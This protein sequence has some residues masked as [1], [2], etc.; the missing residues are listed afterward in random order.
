MITYLRR[1]LQTSFCSTWIY[2]LLLSLIATTVFEVQ[3]SRADTRKFA[4]I[5]GNNQGHNP[6][7]SLRYAE[8]DAQKFY[9][10]LVELGGFEKQNISLQLGSTAEEVWKSVR[11]LE[12]RAVAATRDT[13]DR[14]L[15][16]FYFS[17][18]ASGDVLELG[19][20]AFRFEDLLSF[21]RTS[22]A[23]VRLALIDSCRSG[24][25]VAI[26]GGS[27]GP[28]YDITV[29]D[30]MTSKGYAII[31][32]SSDNELSQESAEIRGAYFTHYLV[33][34]LRGAGDE[35]GD[36]KVTLTEAYSYAYRKTLARTT[37]TVVGSQHP[38]YEFQLEGRGDVVLT[39][40]KEAD[41]KL[42]IVAPE[43]GRLLL[44]DT[45]A[46]SIVAEAVLSKGQRAEIAVRPG[47]YLAYLVTKENA[48]R[49]AD[50]EL[51]PGQQLSLGED[52][53]QT[54][55][56]SQTVSKGGLFL[57]E[58]PEWSH[59]LGVGGMW[60]LW[61]LE[62][63]LSSYGVALQY[64]LETPAGFE[65]GL[66]MT[67]ATRHDVGVSKQYNDFGLGLYLGY[68][69]NW[70]WLSIR[71]GA[72]MA[73]EYMMQVPDS[74]LRYTSAFGYLGLAGIEVPV[75]PLIAGLESGVG[76]RVFQLATD[77]WVHRLDAQVALTLGWRWKQE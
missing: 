19:S 52:N 56:L 77:G 67:W 28:S 3:D 50:T 12:K 2:C 71:A 15:F 54:T 31:T 25:L 21:L 8:K 6:A 20:S 65:P 45:M 62:G 9:Q 40:T 57:K 13:D 38:M 23:D 66:R 76:G 35:S 33:S 5:L 70:K 72:T 75:G 4:V 26:K 1:D 10:V 37:T 63:A 61:G 30:E 34:S 68:V 29:A 42:Q 16:V 43:A 55:T 60:R 47:R 48:V 51:V 11:Q 41:A 22:T 24:K 53:F 64:R 17:G 46:D 44:L 32:S 7:A 59:R 14:S 74:G 73:Y 27:R 18:H 49:S 58:E 39:Q 36:G 69:H